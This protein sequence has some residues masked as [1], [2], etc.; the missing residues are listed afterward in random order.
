MW[1]GLLESRQSKYKK[2]MEAIE[3]SFMAYRIARFMNFAGFFSW[4][5][6]VVGWHSADINFEQDIVMYVNSPGGS[7]TAGNILFLFVLMCDWFVLFT[8]LFSQFFRWIPVYFLALMNYRYGHIWYDEAYS[9]RCFH[10]MC[11]ARC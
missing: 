9:P 8:F 2:D 6:F 4:T 7:V 10:C 11:W 1:G 5:L 3:K